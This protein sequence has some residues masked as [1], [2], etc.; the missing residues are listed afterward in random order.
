MS[1][2][3]KALSLLRPYDIDK[4]KTRIG[5]L[6]DGGYVLADDISPDQAVISYGISSEYDFDKE[7]AERGHDVFMFDHT[8]EGINATNEKMHF[9]REGVAG[10]TDASKNLFSIED[11]LLRHQ[12]AGDRLILKMDVEGAEYDALE[13]ASAETL[14]RFEQIVLEVHGLHL[15][16]D[17]RFVEKFCAVFGKL[18]SYFTLFHVHAN[19][20]DGSNS[21]S[22]V[23]GM[24]VSKLMELSYI[25]SDCVQRRNSQTLYPT[26]LDYPNTRQKD[27]LLWFFPFMPTHLSLEDFAVCGNRVESFHRQDDQRSRERLLISERKQAERQLVNIAIGRPATQSSY[28]PW[29]T[30][31]EAS[32]AVSGAI[33][34]PFAFHTDLEDR[35]WWQVDLL[36]VYPIESIVIH[37]RLDGFA[38]RAR[39]LRVEVSEGAEVWRLVHAGLT[40]F[41]GGASGSPLSLPLN[42]AVNARFVRISLDEKQCLHLA[43]VQIFVHA[44]NIQSS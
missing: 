23:S 18:N 35:P 19:N 6:G 22:V 14:R 36:S 43:Q 27:K 32:Q 29:S 44:Q 41:S 38:D 34:R 40:V 12:V 24:P 25:N 13:S 21:L 9:F 20:Y 4:P 37:N 3:Y 1:P 26:A 39:T 42:G 7:L 8:I 17:L 30:Q 28:S 16:N 10:L 15:L 2:A 5:P 33:Q 11:H 31:S